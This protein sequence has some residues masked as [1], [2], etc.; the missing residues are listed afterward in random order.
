ME[1]LLLFAAIIAAVWLPYIART[2][3]QRIRY[4]YRQ[5]IGYFETSGQQSAK[6][7]L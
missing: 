5:R 6:M 4:A 2:L 3:S 7:E 1:S